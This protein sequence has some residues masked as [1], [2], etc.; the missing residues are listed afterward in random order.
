MKSLRR[1][2]LSTSENFQSQNS[3]WKLSSMWHCSKTSTGDFIFNENI[4][5]LNSYFLY[6]QIFRFS[7]FSDARGRKLLT[8]LYQVIQSRGRRELMLFSL[9]S[10]EPRQKKTTAWTS[11]LSSYIHL[12]SDTR[13]GLTSR[14]FFL[15]LV[16]FT[17]LK[18]PN[19][20]HPQ[21]KH[22]KICRIIHEDVCFHLHHS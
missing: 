11:C 8:K 10:S 9:K 22:R 7:I 12:I 3:F 15:L 19:L 21:R 17:A 4:F 5:P 18:K 1:F 20:L 2:V 6:L 13:R 16:E 14:R